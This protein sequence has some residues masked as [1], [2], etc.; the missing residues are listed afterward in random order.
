[1]VE[2]TV[3]KRKG[4]SHGLKPR[5]VSEEEIQDTIA[6]SVALGRRCLENWPVIV[7]ENLAK[8]TPYVLADVPAT[9]RELSGGKWDSWDAVGYGVA[10]DE[11]VDIFRMVKLW[12]AKE[13]VGL[14]EPLD[15]GEG[16]GFGLY[17][18]WVR[19]AKAF[20][21]G[22]V[23]D[24]KY[25]AGMPRPE[26]VLSEMYGEWVLE[27]FA[28]FCPPHPEDPTGHGGK[29]KIVLE[30]VKA[31]Y[32]TLTAERLQKL[33]TFLA[34]ASHG[35]SRGPVHWLGSNLRAWELWDLLEEASNG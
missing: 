19:E 16:A 26:T 33:T 34:V 7:L 28:Y 2:F 29:F 11:C 15:F 18:R 25:Q 1:M 17:E 27:H 4:R 22:P 10:A 24:E 32:E 13:G 31:N 12:L 30:F 35:R 9:M 21:I 5:E 3:E 14:K 23:F 8:Y 6:V 20:V